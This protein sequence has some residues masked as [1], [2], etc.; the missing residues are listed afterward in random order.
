VLL[1]DFRMTP[2]EKSEFL[3]GLRQQRFWLEAQADDYESGRLGGAM[4]NGIYAAHK[5]AEMAATYR[6][7]ADN[8]T[9]L[10]SAYEES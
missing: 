4:E 10:I 2:Q 8:L 5:C 6:K 7:R 1:L 9:I 3:N